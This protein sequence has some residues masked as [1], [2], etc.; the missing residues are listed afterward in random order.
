VNYTFTSQRVMNKVAVMNG[1][2]YAQAAIEAAQ[3]GW[4][5]SGGDPSAPNTIEARGQY[6]YTWPEALEHPE[7]LWDTDFQDLIYRVAPMHQ[8][9]VNFSGGSEKATYY[10]SA[11]LTD[12]RGIV[13]KSDYQKLS[14]NMKANTH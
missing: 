4:V 8:A 12:Q 2:E 7:T 11:G 9:N 6:K 13:L 1:P 3:N 14:L 5:N 10:F